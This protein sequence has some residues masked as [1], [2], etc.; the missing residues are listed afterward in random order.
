MAVGG[1][2]LTHFRGEW[3]AQLSVG[4]RNILVLLCLLM[5]QQACFSVS[6]VVSEATSV[7]I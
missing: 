5:V 2:L 3:F 7:V 4:V 6:Q 1:A